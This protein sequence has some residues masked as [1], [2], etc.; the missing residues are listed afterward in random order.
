MKSTAATRLDREHPTRVRWTTGVLVF[1]CV[2]GFAAGLAIGLSPLSSPLRSHPSSWFPWLVGAVVTF[3][4]VGVGALSGRRSAHRWAEE[5]RKV[6]A[7]YGITYPSP[8]F[9]AYLVHLHRC[10]P[11]PSTQ[12]SSVSTSWAIRSAVGLAASGGAALLVPALRTLEAAGVMAGAAFALLYLAA[13]AA[14]RDCRVEFRRESILLYAADQAA[15]ER[16]Q[17][18]RQ[19]QSPSP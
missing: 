13:T 12:G 5:V 14:E 3:A 17:W 9:G 19:H 4:L 10:T 18:I 11:S 8:A 7:Q 16:L 15:A 2:W 1:A 6:A